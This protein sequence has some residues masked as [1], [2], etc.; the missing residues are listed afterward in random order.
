[1]PAFIDQHGATQQVTLDVAMYRE[2]A[3]AG[4]SLPQYLATKFPTNVEKHGSTFQ[5]LCASEGIFMR[6]N[7][8]LGIR[9]TTMAQIS[10]AIT[11]DAAPASRILF[12]AVLLQ[13]IEDKL[14]VNRS[15]TANALESM[16]AFNEDVQGDRYEQPQINYTG[17]E[18]GRSQ[19]IAQLAAPTSMVTITSS[20]KSYK[21]PTFALGLE[22]AEQ[23]LKASTLDFVALSL[24]RQASVQANER[25]QNYM[26]ALYAGDVD[27]G[28]AS[29]SSLGRVTAASSLDSTSTGGVLT[30][31][32]WTKFLVKDA[33]K[34]T[35]DY[36]V[37]DIDGALAIE[38][39]T[40]RPVV[41][42]DDPKSPRINTLM[43][44]VNPLW[45]T[46]V[47]LFLTLDPA[48]PAGT[49]MGLDSN[50]AIRR[51]RSLTA[52]YQAIENYVMRRTVAMRFDFG[53]TV[54]R[55]YDEAYDVLTLT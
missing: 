22:V 17:P 9:P 21:I 33:V 41:T 49:L 7:K 55:M 11:K 45:P 47:K 40:G 42:A 5:Q 43:E 31:K 53:E 52:D 13:A 38:N 24:A 15:M 12:P 32:A 28:Q 30:Q 4:T 18:A 27:N 16:I 6:P 14:S 35:I 3:E 1:M 8:E 10:G 51:A 48:W 23:A 34:R 44:V 39:R 36:I 20:D 54:G 26:M 2:A 25:A 46:Q 19:G 37:T 29:L 50:W